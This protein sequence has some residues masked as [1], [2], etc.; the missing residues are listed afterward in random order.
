M[1]GEYCPL[2]TVVRA[3]WREPGLAYCEKGD[4]AWYDPEFKCCAVAPP[5]NNLASPAVAYEGVGV[6]EES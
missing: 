4:C 6:D 3:I 5:I 1:S 2:L